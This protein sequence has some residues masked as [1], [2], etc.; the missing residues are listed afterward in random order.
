MSAQEIMTAA[1][2]CEQA[3]WEQICRW[4]S[5][6][7]G[8][9]FSAPEFPSF[10][11][12]QQLRD[13]WLQDVDA[14]TAFE[15]AERYFAERKLTCG[16]WSPASGQELAPVESLM[17]EKGWRRESLVAMGMADASAAPEEPAEIEGIRILPARAMRRAYRK[18]L[19]AIWTDTTVG[20]AAFERLDDANYDVL[21]A[22]RE[23][24]AIGQ[25]AY[26]EVGDFARIRDFFVTDG[27]D[28][29]AIGRLLMAHALLIARR[30]LPR[31][32]VTCVAEE[33]AR[34]RALFES[35]GF[36]AAGELVRF[37]RPA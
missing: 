27:E 34:Q 35:C 31:V 15:N 10:S 36:A 16:I 18:L 32:L 4:E 12:A 13:V 20:D 29:E 24:E 33:D 11:E 5:L 7:Y 3:W 14:A 23:K 21:L 17:C 25:I 28:F 22:V 19:D 6:S 2:R 1:R 9:A 26:H 37:R 30:L 8:V